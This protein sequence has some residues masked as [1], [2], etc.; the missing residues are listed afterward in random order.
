M[1]KP[2]I[3]LACLKYD[4]TSAIFN[5]QVKLDGVELEVVEVRDVAR[6][7]TSMF[8]GEFDVGEFSTT[9]LIFSRSRNKGDLIGI[10][11]FPMRSFRHSFIFYNTAANISGPQSL[12]GKRIGFGEWIQTAA[13][14]VR[15]ILAEEYGLSPKDMTFQ[16]C[17]VHHWGNLEEKDEIKP[18]DGSLIEWV[19]FQGESR[20]DLTNQALVEGK[21]DVLVFP[22]APM[23]FLQRNPKIERLFKNHREVELAYFKK[24]RIFPIMHIVVMKRSLAE[25][26]PDLPEKLFKLFS[27][28]KKIGREGTRSDWRVDLV[29]KS[30]YL[31]DEAEIFSGDPWA[32]GLKKNE[33]VLEKLI[34]Y[35]YNQGVAVAKVSPKDLFAPSTWELADLG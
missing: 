8:R 18:R 21:I 27:E 26:H 30:S 9:E 28:A 6:G 11:V 16:S 13:V 15:G 35:C 19:D 5:G 17:A 12:K 22:R 4:R 10:P 1:A 14:W 33:H 29:W 32:Y 3:K 7:F 20:Y 24:T 25:K 31:E 23:S 34:S 2:R